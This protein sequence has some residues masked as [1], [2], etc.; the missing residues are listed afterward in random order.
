M[1]KKRDFNR[2]RSQ[3]WDAVAQWYAGWSGRD[4]SHYHR[5]LAVPMLLLYFVAILIGWIVQR[6]RRKREATA[7]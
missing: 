6:R 5:T 4:G 3:S 7:A 2:A 1:T